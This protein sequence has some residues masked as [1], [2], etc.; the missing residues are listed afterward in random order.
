MLRAV[1]VGIPIGLTFVDCFGYVA[2]VEGISMQ[3][4]LNPD[5]NGNNDFVFL[6]RWSSRSFRYNRGDMV[7][8]I[9]P[10]DPSQK[11]IKRIIALEGDLI[12][13][14]GYKSRY[15]RIPEGH[16]WVEGDHTGHSLD[17]NFFGPVA[18]G[19]VTA[20]A[21]QIVWPPN[22]WQ[23]LKSELPSDRIPLNLRGVSGRRVDSSEATDKLDT[24]E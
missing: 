17:S 22:R 13:T 20:R 8:L 19:L 6:S 1:A 16:C 12:R 4:A 3:P 2:K 9:S 5:S 10:K 11:I 14:I 15:I 24:E 7:S 23:Q 21:S 18:I